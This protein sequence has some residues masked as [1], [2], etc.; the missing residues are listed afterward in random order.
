MHAKRSLRAEFTFFL[1]YALVAQV[2]AQPAGQLQGKVIEFPNLDPVELGWGWDERRAGSPRQ[3]CIEFRPAQEDYVD[4]RMS[5]QLANDHEALSRAL[6]VSVAGK[7]KSMAGA[8]FSASANFAH[9]ASLTSTGE[10]VAILAEAMTAPQF[11]AP[12]DGPDP[13]ASALNMSPDGSRVDMKTFYRGG[14]VR[15]KEDLRKLAANNPADFVKACG[16]GFVA[17]I[18]RGAR[19]NGLMTFR[20]VESKDRQELRVSAQGSGAGFSMNASMNTLVEKYGKTGKL[21]IKFEQLGGSN[22]DLPM[23]R[24]GLLSAVSGL[25]AE[26]TAQPRAFLMVVQGYSSL[27]DWPDKVVLPE[28]TDEEVLTRSYFRLITLMGFANEALHNPGFLLKFDTSR[29]EVVKLHDQMLA[30]RDTLRALVSACQQG[31]CAAG[32]WREW[33]DMP[34][35][36]R[37]PMAGG[38]DSLVF[39]ANVDGVDRIPKAVADHRVSRW[40]VETDRWRCQYESECMKQG[41]VEGYRD[42]IRQNVAQSMGLP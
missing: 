27:P 42:K 1:A 13:K 15:L 33:S 24:T 37:M 41:D 17:V 31:P 38:F 6:N 32:K 21:D 7:M 28:L 9:N 11:V 14:A 22:K 16:T 12:L 23:D 30:D 2:A 35:R 25:P 26:A 5:L 19:V 20:E 36:A 29:P 10:H 8:K 40:I 4:K 34:Y 18:H 39:P 3:I